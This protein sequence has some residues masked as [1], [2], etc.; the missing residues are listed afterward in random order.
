MF[1]GLL[2]F[3][4]QYHTTVVK[5][6][7][8]TFSYDSSKLLIQSYLYYYHHILSRLNHPLSESNYRCLMLIRKKVL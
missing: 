8:I 3:N 1:V 6:N 7:T 2:F 5:N 4:T